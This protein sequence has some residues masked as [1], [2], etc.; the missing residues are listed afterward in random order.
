[1]AATA[2][3]NANGTSHA[4]AYRHLEERDHPWRRE[5]FLK[6]RNMTAG[7]LVYWMRTNQFSIEETAEIWDLPVETVK[8]AVLY[9][10]RN[11]QLIEEDVD[12]E[13]RRAEAVATHIGPAALSR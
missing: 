4:E 13:R 5:L 9:Y 10:E 8:E 12:E 2:R 11:R 1:M 7:H 3:A 6:G